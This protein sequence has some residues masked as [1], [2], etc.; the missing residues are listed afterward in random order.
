[1]FTVLWRDQNGNYIINYRAEKQFHNNNS[2]VTCAS[3][4]TDSCRCLLYRQPA[5]KATFTR[6]KITC[7]KI[8]LLHCKYVRPWLTRLKAINVDVRPFGSEKLMRSLMSMINKKTYSRSRRK[9]VQQT[10]TWPANWLYNWAVC[11]V[12]AVSLKRFLT[13]PT[14]CQLFLFLTHGKSPREPSGPSGCEDV[15]SSSHTEVASLL[16]ANK[17]I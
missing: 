3:L 5:I 13:T 15:T 16:T 12:S 10:E 17:Q 1:M 14:F 9:A 7:D 2:H 6:L 11:Q 8:T 4:G